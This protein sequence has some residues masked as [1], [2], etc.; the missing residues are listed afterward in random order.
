M[1]RL[2]RRF[3]IQETG[4]ESTEPLHAADVIHATLRVRSGAE[5][6]DLIRQTNPGTHLGHEDRPDRWMKDNDV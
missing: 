4:I 2:L 1:Q 5:M 3:E 6:A